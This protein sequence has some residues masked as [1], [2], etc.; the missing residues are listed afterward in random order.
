MTDDL[1]ESMRDFRAL[2]QMGCTPDEVYIGLYSEPGP[3]YLELTKTHETAIISEP[4]E[5]GSSLPL[6]ASAALP[7]CDV[8]GAFFLLNNSAERQEDDQVLS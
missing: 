6:S 5:A 1:L 3:W 4:A 7:P 2:L 8:A